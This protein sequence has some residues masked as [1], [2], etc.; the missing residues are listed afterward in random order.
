MPMRFARLSETSL[1]WSTVFVHR[2]A[3]GRVPRHLLQHPRV[4]VG[5]G[6]MSERV[7]T[8]MLWIDSRHPPLR[9]HVPDV[10]AV[11]PAPDELRARL[12]DVRQHETEPRGRAGPH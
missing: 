6:E 8:R 1:H 3:G 9:S 12:L 2:S 7:V 4:A 10:A 11:D 5:I